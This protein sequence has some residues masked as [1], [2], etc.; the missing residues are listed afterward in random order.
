M[1]P[2]APYPIHGIGSNP[3]PEWDLSLLSSVL[4][5]RL[6]ISTLVV[7]TLL[8]DKTEPGDVGGILPSTLE[9]LNHLFLK[10]SYKVG[11]SVISI[12][13]TEAQRG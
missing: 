13:K 4:Q 9:V 6:L 7:Q 12:K 8:L 2:A 1:A 3:W 11:T 5:A 10:Q